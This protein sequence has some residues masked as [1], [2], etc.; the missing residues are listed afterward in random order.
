MNIE[1]QINEELEKFKNKVYA[2][3]VKI[4]VNISEL[5]KIGISSLAPQS[6]GINAIKLK[7][8]HST[9]KEEITNGMLS[10]I[11][12]IIVSAPFGKLY[13]GIEFEKALKKHHELENFI[14]CY[15]Q[16]VQDF[17]EKLKMKRATLLALS[18]GASIGD[19][20][21]ILPQA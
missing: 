6:H 12:K 13:E 15:N 14:L 5:L 10:D 3:K 21:R 16:I 11:I 18:T 1:Q 19:M 4:P 7:S 17:Q 20:R 8:L 9:K 2:G